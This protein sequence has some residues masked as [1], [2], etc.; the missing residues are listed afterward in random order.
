[1]RQR[2]SGVF[3]LSLSFSAI[4]IR[5]GNAKSSEEEVFAARRVAARGAAGAGGV[6]SLFH[7][8]PPYPRA[9]GVRA[10]DDGAIGILSITDTHTDKNGFNHVEGSKTARVAALAFFFPNPQFS[11]IL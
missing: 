6:L 2:A 10:K 3:R 4:F 8:I 1:M 7:R 11:P 9:F 5:F